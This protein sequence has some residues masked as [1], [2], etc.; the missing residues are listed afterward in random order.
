MTEKLTGRKDAASQEQDTDF[1]SVHFTVEV[2][3]NDVESGCDESANNPE[4]EQLKKIFT[5]EVRW[6]G[7]DNCDSRTPLETK[8]KGH[9]GITKAEQLSYSEGA[10]TALQS[11]TYCPFQIES[12]GLILFGI[13]EE[14]GLR[15]LQRRKSLLYRNASSPQRHILCASGK[16]NMAG[17]AQ[18]YREVE[19]FHSV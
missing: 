16:A 15:L 1:M 5:A 11:N 13:S 18:G 10:D 12:E 9:Y 3:G 8:H 2:S 19:Y 7:P 17:R 4:D 14:N 6:Q